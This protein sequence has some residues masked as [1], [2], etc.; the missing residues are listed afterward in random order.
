MAIPPLSGPLAPRLAEAKSLIARGDHAAALPILTRLRRK[1]EHPDVAL[2]LARVQMAMGDDGP[3]RANFEAVLAVSPSVDFVYL[4]IARLHQRQD[5]VDLALVT[6]DRLLRVNPAHLRGLVLKAELLH[7]K[8]EYEAGRKLLQPLFDKSVHDHAMLFEHGRLCALLGDDAAA[9]K[10][11]RASFNAVGD[12]GPAGAKQMHQ[13]NCLYELAALYERQGQHDK[14]WVAATEAN[15]L[16][17]RPFDPDAHDLMINRMTAA[18]TPEAFASVPVSRHEDELPVFIL[19]MPRSGTSLVEQILGSHPQVHAG[20]ERARLHREIAAMEPHEDRLPA[21][22]ER[23]GDLTQRAVD[24]GAA[25]YLKDLRRLSRDAARITDK[26]PF[27]FLAIGL[28]VRM[29]PGARII[30]C[31][32]H[33]LD[34]AV[35]CYFQSFMGSV[36]FANS[37]PHIARFQAAHDQLVDHWRSL[38]DGDPHGSG[39]RLIQVPYEELTADQ[40]TWSRRLVEHV[41]LSWDDACLRFHEAERV[42][43]TASADQVRRPMYRSSVER[44]RHYET[45]L[46]PMITAMENRERERAGE[47]EG[48]AGAPADGQSPVAE[49]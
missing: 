25:A 8:G 43:H 13:A 41:G 40:D 37:L 42:T 6:V 5:N 9:E 16:V 7:L 33:P 15:S 20:G 12:Q 48:G 45:Q 10:S 26:Q 28:I 47:G 36:W 35:S 21:R 24:R 4:A 22:I 29:F 44:W 27:N 38:L 23:P 39:S 14:A 19:G 17:P 34:V 46:A 3:A 32:R 31:T 18:W 30:H 49:P 1:S 2:N 11:L